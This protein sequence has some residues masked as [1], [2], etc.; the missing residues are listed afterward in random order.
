MYRLIIYINEYKIVFEFFKKTRSRSLKYLEYS[1]FRMKPECLFVVVGIFL[2]YFLPGADG[3]RVVTRRRTVARGQARALLARTATDPPKEIAAEIK[4][5]SVVQAKARSAIEKQ[6]VLLDKS[7]GRVKELKGM[8]RSALREGLAQK[9]WVDNTNHMIKQL[10]KQKKSIKLK[11][12][13][14]RL[15]P[16]LK[17]AKKHQ[18]QLLREQ[19]QW[20]STNNEMSSKVKDIVEQLKAL[21]GESD[22]LNEEMKE[23]T[24]SGSGKKE[25]NGTKAENAKK[26]D[27]NSSE[28]KGDDEDTKKKKKKLDLDKLLNVLDD[29]S[30][31]EA[32]LNETEW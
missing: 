11:Y 2:L 24:G 7:H 6:N 22:T 12:D 14:K 23:D 21:K 16:V 26:K 19:N 18:D 1:I 27:K 29:P 20:K 8:L 32:G 13:L 10:E 25:G 3:S 30:S 5:L 9:R 15:K 4:K 28:K 31:E 17:E